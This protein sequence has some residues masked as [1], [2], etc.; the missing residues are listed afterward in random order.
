MEHPA[1]G[2]EATVRLTVDTARTA[3]AMG[4]GSL[5][6]LATHAVVALM[7][8]AACR[9]LEN[10]LEPGI[11]TVGTLIRV[12]HLSATPVG[13]AVTAKAVLTQTDGRKY[14]FDVEAYDSAGLIAKGT[15]ERFSVKSE[16]FMEKTN[17][18]LTQTERSV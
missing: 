4:S 11:T 1:I 13:A 5:P 12:E 18:K 16:R 17:Q 8:Q 9:V 2:A 14:C 3:L 10:T 15:H 6:V 7:E